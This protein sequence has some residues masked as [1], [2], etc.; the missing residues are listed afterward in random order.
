MIRMFIGY[1]HAENVAHNVMVNSIQRHA[2]Q[3]VSIAQ[4]ALHQLKHVLHRERHPLQSNE[5]AF[6]RWLVP[7][8]C[9]YKGWAIWADCD[10]LFFDD[11]AKLWALRNQK[12]AV[13]VVKHNHIPREQ[14]KYLGTTQTSYDRKNWSSVVMFNCEKCKALTP[15][16]IHNADGLHLHQF[17]WLKDEEIGEIPAEWNYLVGY[18][19]REDVGEVKNAHFTIGGPYFDEYA[20]TEFA[21]EWWAEY[22][23]MTHCESAARPK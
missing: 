22:K 12:Y 14:T 13:Q 18:Q 4:I 16:L 20:D 23:D 11:V 15:R 3:P 21:E 19:D 2:S 9:N 6:S 17:K 1:D 8:L 10:M 5:F 7:Y